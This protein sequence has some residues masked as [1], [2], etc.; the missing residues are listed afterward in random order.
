ME[1]LPGEPLLSRDNLDALKTDNVA[2]GNLPGLA[3][4]GIEAASLEAV[5]PDV[6]ARRDSVARLE[7]SRRGA[8]R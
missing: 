3:A 7:P 5:M 1:C 2:S 6:M 8:G 4:L